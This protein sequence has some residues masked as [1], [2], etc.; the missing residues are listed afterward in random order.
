M[1]M[2]LRQKK[3]KVLIFLLLPRNNLLVLKYRKN[4]YLKLQ[5]LKYDPNTSKY[6]VCFWDT[7]GDEDGNPVPTMGD[8]Y[9]SESGIYLKNEL[10]NLANQSLIIGDVRGKGL[11]LA[12]E[13]VKNKQFKALLE[14][15]VRAV[16]RI[17][18]IGIEEGILLYT[19]KTAAGAFGEWI[20]VTPALTIT[21]AQVD[22]LV[23]LLTKTIF[24]FEKE[25][26]D[27]GFLNTSE[28]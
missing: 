27:G 10:I 8:T 19:R 12:I 26:K 1:S 20:M 7:S 2:Q 13:I 3:H 24:L 14:E 9:A 28:E 17:L 6:Y 18:E 11:L 22:E 15:Q 4:K 5:W 25:L 23:K 16:Y 21:K